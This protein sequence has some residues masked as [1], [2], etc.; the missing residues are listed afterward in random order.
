M[1][2]VIISLSSLFLSLSLHLPSPLPISPLPPFTP[3]F[4]SFL[5]QAMELE[6]RHLFL[7]TWQISSSHLTTTSWVG[8]RRGRSQQ[9][10][11]TRGSLDRRKRTHVLPRNSI[12]RS[13]KLLLLRLVY[14]VANHVTVTL[15]MRF[16]LML[17]CMSINITLVVDSNVSMYTYLVICVHV[18]TLYPP[19]IHV[20][21]YS[22]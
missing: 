19:Y 18:Y 13:S 8:V 4:P 2:N 6:A 9:W 20:L 3:S 1:Y 16:S 12:P 21:H 10:T 11:R 14:S 22:V 17:L 15:H 7:L 5:L